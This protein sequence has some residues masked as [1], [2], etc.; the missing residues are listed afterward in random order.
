[1]TQEEAHGLMNHRISDQMVIVDDQIQRAMP[2]RQLN[3]ELRKKRS[4]TD[5]LPFLHHHF[6]GGA[7]TVSGLLYRGNQ[8]A[9]KTLLLV[10]ALIQ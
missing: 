8:I 4:Q 2:F 5:I 10:V 7:M 6:A 3:K 1:M 9:G